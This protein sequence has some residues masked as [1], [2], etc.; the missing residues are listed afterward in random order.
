M[1]WIILVGIFVLLGVAS[2]AQKVQV[3][4]ESSNEPVE[5]AII[6]A[7]DQ[8]TFATSDLQGFADVSMFGPAEQ[9]MVQHPSFHPYSFTLSELSP[10]DPRLYLKEKVIRIDE[11]VISANKWE[12]NKTELPFEILSIEA[13]EMTFSNP[14]T[15][16]DML[17][18]TGQVFVQ[19]SQLGGGSPMIRGF[20]ANS[21][22]IVVDGVR[23]N[24]TIFR[25]GN[26]QNVIN[27]DPNFL[28]SSEVIFGPGTVV[29]GSDALGGVMDFHT[30]GGRF[31]KSD[32]RIVNA[33]LLA[34]YSSANNEKTISGNIRMAND[35]FAYLGSI[36]FSDFDDLRTGAQRPSAHPDFGKRLEY[37]ETLD[38]T[39]SIVKNDNVNL[40]RFSGYRQWSTLQKVSFR[41]KDR[42]ELGYSFHY[43]TTSDIPRYDRLTQYEGENLKYAVWKYG[44]QSWMMNALKLKYYQ[45]CQLFD[46]A[47]VTIA[48]QLF[49]ESRHDRRFAEELLRNRFERVNV[50]SLN[51]DLEKVLSPTN[52]L[53]Y[54][55]EYTFNHV[56]SSAY[57]QNIE[58][59][60]RESI[61]TRYPAGGSDVHSMALYGSYKHS[62]RNQL[63]LSTGLRFSYQN[64]RSKF[65]N[66]QFADHVNANSALNGNIGLVYKP[67]E[68]WNLSGMLSTGFRAPNVD[69]VSKV[70][71]SE[72]GNVIVP[73]P[74]LKP[75]YSYNLELSASRYVQDRVVLDATVFYSF[76]R[77]AMVRGDFMI[78]GQDSIIYDGEL[79]KVQAIVN[80]GRANIYGF[81]AGMKAEI[82]QNWSSSFHLN[83][84]QGRD[85]VEDEPLRHTTPL[86]GNFSVVYH[87]QKVK[88][89]FFVRFN[90]KRS[91]EDLP[92]SERNKL[93]LYSSDGSL[94][95]YT[96]NARVDYKLTDYLSLNAAVE[97]MLDHHYR[98]YSSGISAPGRNFIV[99]LRVAF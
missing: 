89:E 96:L 80:T 10:K 46:E 68:K 19:K 27:I 77:D 60:D 41:R 2:L 99:A 61:S 69:D 33:D 54:G 18:A 36:S 21:V 65:N 62:F 45:S 38:G 74:S 35:K 95:W 79:S 7:D 55:L 49:E 31:S 76:L 59:G 78:N 34:R 82:S 83:Y 93:H 43:S 6:Y 14:Q 50:V 97:N 16:A 56:N 85:M 51:A 81:S 25:S 20:G 72:P 3:L 30:K 11:V 13:S 57:S 87:R 91:F 32:K 8:S 48:H 88:G 23:M 26:L 66:E 4:E 17:E 58:S 86:F 28:E 29:Y 84:T 12:Q 52:Q 1:R 90:G 22:L 94:A 39:D 44:P 67:D 75:E 63:Y 53:F 71:D 9:L 5:G 15:S 70:F 73:N 42:Y 40:Q 24:N 98:T 92:P 64:L 47:R 37:V